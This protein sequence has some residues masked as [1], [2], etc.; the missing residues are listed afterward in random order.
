MTGSE[1]SPLLRREVIALGGDRGSRRGQAARGSR[2]SRFNRAGIGL[3]MVM[4]LSCYRESVQ[5]EVTVQHEAPQ[6]EA[7]PTASVQRPGYA[8]VRQRIEEARL[9]LARRHAQ[10]E[11]PSDKAQVLDQARET[12]VTAVSDDIF[13]Q[14]FGTPWDFNGTTETPGEGKIACG[15]FV[16]T[17]LRDVGFKVQRVLL[18]QQASELIIKSLTS[19][20]HI[21]RFSDTPIETFVGA[22]HDLGPGLYVVGLDIHTGFILHDDEGVWFVHSSYVYPVEV[23]KEPAQTSPILRSSRYRVVGKVSADDELLVKWLQGYAIP[24]KTP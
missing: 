9:G 21:R 10:C 8:E 20:A 7:T 11:S 2:W 14:W 1:R 18:A 19:E 3:G 15:Y 4:L 17:V 16:T 22:I 6:Q 12:L 5:H 24:T 23:L 13:P